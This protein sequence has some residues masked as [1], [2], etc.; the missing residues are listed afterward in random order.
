MKNAI[1]IERKQPCLYRT[2]RAGCGPI[3]LEGE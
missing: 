3:D 1:I 2:T